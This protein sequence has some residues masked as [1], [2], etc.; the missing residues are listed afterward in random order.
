MLSIIYFE[1]PLRF[2]NGESHIG[3][4]IRA[5]NIPIASFTIVGA[6]V[7]PHRCKNANHEPAETTGPYMTP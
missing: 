3:D 6:P 7:I 4:K 1:F 2:Y 5:I